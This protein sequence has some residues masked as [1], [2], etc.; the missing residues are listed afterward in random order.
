MF[1]MCSIQFLMLQTPH[2]RLKA[3]HL[4]FYCFWVV[5]WI[6]WW[7]IYVKI[8]K[9]Q[10]KYFIFLLRL[11]GKNLSDFAMQ[12]SIT[13]YPFLMKSRGEKDWNE[14]KAKYLKSRKIELWSLIFDNCSK[15][16]LAWNCWSCLEICSGTCFTSTIFVVSPL[17]N[18][19]A[20]FW[21]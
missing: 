20:T 17:Q 19:S 15:A 8:P 14:N 18:M 12:T 6:Y 13:S 3:L 21:D 1:P 16:F 7:K 5:L 11:H 9:I 4:N 10:H 2:E